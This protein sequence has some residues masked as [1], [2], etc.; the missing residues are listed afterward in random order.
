MGRFCNNRGRFTITSAG[1]SL[2]FLYRTSRNTSEHDFQ[3]IYETEK[4]LRDPRILGEQCVTDIQCIANNASCVDSICKCEIDFYNWDEATCA[5]KKAWNS[6]CYESKECKTEFCDAVD[7][8][9]LCPPNTIIDENYNYCLDNTGKTEFPTSSPK[10]WMIPFLL[11]VFLI[12]ALL[13]AATVILAR[14]KGYCLMRRD[15][16]AAYTYSE[17]MSTSN[18]LY[19]M[20]TDD[21]SSH[22]GSVIS[23]NVSGCDGRHRIRLSNFLNT[24][25][26]MCDD[27]NWPEDDFRKSCNLVQQSQQILDLLQKTDTKTGI[28]PFYHMILID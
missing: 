25:Q 20:S 11:F 2:Y 23:I 19:G 14:R 6:A 16:N 24:Y 26:E 8:L 22:R 4:A 21:K 7:K 18:P 10:Y 5:K 27:M 15:Q 17:L 12:I 9:C 13:I 1:S 28:K 3:I